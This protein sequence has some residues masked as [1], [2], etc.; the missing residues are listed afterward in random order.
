MKI[1]VG[2]QTIYTRSAKEYMKKKQKKKKLLFTLLL[3]LTFVVGLFPLGPKGANA[4]PL[5][6][7]IS[8]TEIISTVEQTTEPEDSEKVIR[9]E[10]ES[11][12]SL[13]ND[14]ETKLME[15]NSVEEK[16]TLDTQ[17]ENEE[18]LPIQ[19]KEVVEETLDFQENKTKEESITEEKKSA[20]SSK[21]K[22]LLS[23]KVKTKKEENTSNIAEYAPQV[24]KQTKIVLPNSIYQATNKKAGL[25]DTIRVNKT[26]ERI[27]GL[28]RTYEVTLDITGTPQEAPVDVVLVIDRSGSMDS[29]TT[30]YEAISSEP[31][32]SKTYYIKI[33]GNY[34]TISYSRYGWSYSL[35]NGW[36]YVNRYVEWDANGDDKNPGNTYW[37]SL[38]SKPFYEKTEKTRLYYAKQAAINFA[39]RVLGPNGVP[40]SRVSVVSFS[41]PTS[42]YDNGNQNQAST[43]LDLNDNLSS[44]T[45]KINA[46]SAVGGTNTEAGFKQG[47]SVIQGATSKQNPNS[48]KVVIMLTDGLP[49]ASNGN[50]YADTTNINHVH[51]QKAIAAGKNIYQND[52]ADVFTIGLTTGMNSTEKTLADHILTQAQNKGY[53][54]APDATDLDEIFDAISKSLGYAATNAKVEDKIG[55]HFELIEDS[56]PDGVS[57][58]SNTRVISWNPGTIVEKAQLVYKVKAKADFAGG[59]ADTNEFAT[60]TFKDVF[61][62]SGIKK[63]F[64]K[65][66]VDVPS[67]IKVSL[68]DANIVLGDSIS[69]GT[70]KKPGGE[71]YMSPV[72]GGDNDGKTFSYEWRVVGS[73]TVISR[74]KNPSVSPTKDTEYELTVI[75]SNGCK[76]KARMKVFPRVAGTKIEA[77]KTWVGG[78]SSDHTAVTLVLYRTVKNG[79]QT[80]VNGF[81]PSITGKAPTFNY[82]WENLPKT[83]NEGNPYT[84][85]VKE[86]GVVENKVIIN[87]NE[88]IVTQDGNAITNTY[89]SPKTDIVAE[90]IWKGGFKEKPIIQIQLYR[91]GSPFESPV[92]LK[93]PRTTYKWKDLDLNDNNGKNYNYTVKEVGVAEYHTKEENGLTIKNT[94]E[95]GVL[96]IS[97]KVTGN[98]GDKA[99]LFDVVVSFILPE[100][101]TLESPITYVGGKYTTEML[102]DGLQVT[103]QIKDGETIEF[104]SIPYG[105]KYEVK[106]KDYTSEKYKENHQ[107]SDPD[108]QLDS[109]VETVEIINSKEVIIDTGIALDS[110]P[111]II[112]LL[113]LATGGIGKLIWK[114]KQTDLD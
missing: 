111:Y 86:K 90:K 43:D 16:E 22:E 113:L 40:G 57:Y 18:A 96:K 55:D 48:N 101:K 32:P 68:T 33:N 24:T 85:S 39:G 110:L 102:V 95:D 99:K 100:G 5:D 58:N 46:I 62:T 56:L 74:D 72:T 49:T 88:Y 112:I 92:S 65:P 17:A 83:D 78:P 19:G 103:I 47:Q 54:P 29:I 114:R 35:W 6:E 89:K 91:N 9:D 8:E 42:I 30:E 77:T 79:Q 31:D 61:G 44:V 71:N 21:T 28:C 3:L 105:V 2:G 13:K 1:F 25:E 15:T 66:N 80:I 14:K 12:N 23:E 108:K 84:Y 87:G 93:S 97:K 7:L 64:P 107:F 37:E 20:Q 36:Y 59:L 63:T 45:K 53:S 76:A 106:E 52:I 60:L 38:V 81:T 4:D 109:K 98:F 41:G 51:I 94:H 11:D 26:A 50:R 82:I 73:D 34:Q 69:L 104:K 67:L 27:K 10:F 70:G 75:D